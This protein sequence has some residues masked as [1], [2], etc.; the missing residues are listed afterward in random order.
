MDYVFTM[1][2]LDALQNVFEDFFRVISRQTTLLFED[3]F[4]SAS[5]IKLFNQVEVIMLFESLNQLEDVGRFE[6]SKD[7]GLFFG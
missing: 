3:R 6:S 4:K 7:S 1:Q 2:I 5:V